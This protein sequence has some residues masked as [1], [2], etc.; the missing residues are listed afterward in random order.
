MGK[1]L[2][3]FITLMLSMSLVACGSQTKKT[4]PIKNEE[5]SK[6]IVKALIKRW[7]YIDAEDENKEFDTVKED[8]NYYWVVPI[9]KELSVLKEYKE[10]KF[11]NELVGEQFKKYVETLEKQSKV[12]D[13]VTS[14]S[15]YLDDSNYT[16][17][18]ATRTK[19]LN[20]LNRLLKLDITEKYKKNFDEVLNNDTTYDESYITQDAVELKDIT[21][22][23]KKEDDDWYDIRFTLTNK[24]IYNFSEVVIHVSLQDSSGK[25][26]GDDQY[27][28]VEAV[29]AHQ[30]RTGEVSIEKED[31]KDAVKLEIV[32]YELIAD[33]DTTKEQ[34]YD[35]SIYAKLKFKEPIT[36]DLN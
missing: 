32:G 23:E 9:K 1:R 8:Y 12:Y 11:E 31:M 26:L 10:A 25:I 4:G 15:R 17:Y 6:I 7:D 33:E 36:H 19:L 2:K 28:S 14:N 20:A 22:N 13:N 5:L 3:I 24:T 27:N 21:W 16:Y 29:E 18:G 30:S 34:G 35:G